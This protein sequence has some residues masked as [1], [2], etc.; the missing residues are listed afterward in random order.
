[1]LLALAPA[2]GRAAD[3]PAISLFD[4]EDGQLDMSAMLASASGFLPVP[5]LITE[6]AVG[7]GGGAA[8]L[9]FHDSIADQA[10]RA[11]AGHPG[12]NPK[13]VP[14]PSISGVAGAGTENGTWA[15]GAFHLGIWRE[16]TVRYLGGVGYAS[17]NYD[18]YGPAGRGVPVNVEGAGLLQQAMFRMGKSDF[19]A[20]ANYKLI[21]ATAKAE[22]LSTLPPP[23]GEGV[24]VVSGGASPILEYDTR[25]NIFTPNHGIN[26]KFEW[27]HFDDWLG[28]DNRFDLVAFNNRLWMPLSDALVLGI[29]ADGDFSSGDVPFYM[30]PYV[31]IRG[32]PAMRYQGD[33]VVTT[34]AELRW[35][36]THRW[37]LVGFAG[38]GWTARGDLP[39]LGENGNHPAGGVGFRYLLARLFKLRAGIDVGF[40]EADAAVYLTMGNAWNM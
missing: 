36:V 1:V 19:F 3:G 34:E 21:A 22:W 12:G 24:E 14:P 13:R 20:G 31:Q 15:A 35:D 29:R 5:I 4:P 40:S 37:S 8:L 7:Y 23:A 30:V 25:D 28:S 9:F 11:A 18:L 33:H 16:D 17:V 39:E 10:K 32:I 2:V 6:P 27:T 26:S 38:T